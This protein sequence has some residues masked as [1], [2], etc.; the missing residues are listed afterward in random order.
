MRVVVGCVMLLAA[1]SIIASSFP[2]SPTVFAANGPTPIVIYERAQPSLL[3]WVLL[4]VIC[5]GGAFQVAIGL[6]SLFGSPPL[7]SDKS[8]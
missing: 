5:L 1:G 8:P 4:V 7:M 6:S 3:G 2:H